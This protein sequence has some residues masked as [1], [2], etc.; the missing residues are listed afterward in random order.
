MMM[1]RDAWAQLGSLIPS[2]MFLWAMF[3]QYFPEHLCDYI[4]SYSRKLVRFM[5]PNI[6]FTFH[7]FSGE[8]FNRS[9]AYAAIETYLG[10]GSSRE[11]KKLEAAVVKD[12]SQ[13]VLL[14]MDEN[15]EVTDEFEGVKLRWDSKKTTP[16][17]QSFSRYAESK[18]KR[19]YKLTFH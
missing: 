15:E 1:M 8:H 7:G 6:Q 11:A 10:E 14:S 2:I 12:S 17:T 5:S 13:S 16:R 19:Y 3:D 9:E 4:L 18:E